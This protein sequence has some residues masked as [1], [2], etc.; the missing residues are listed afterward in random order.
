MIADP[1]PTTF[2]LEDPHIAA[3]VTQ[4]NLLRIEVHLLAP[5]EILSAPARD[6]HTRQHQEVAVV[7]TSPVALHSMTEIET[8]TATEIE[9]PDPASPTDHGTMRDRIGGEIEI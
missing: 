9:I 4:L 8:E 5:R 1:H 6:F 3:Q 2:S 7:L